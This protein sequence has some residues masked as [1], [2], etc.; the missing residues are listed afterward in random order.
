MNVEVVVGGAVPGQGSGSRGCPARPLGAGKEGHAGAGEV[1]LDG[2]GVLVIADRG[3]QRRG[4][5]EPAQ[6]V[7]HVCRRPA[8]V[9]NGAPRR[10]DDVHQGLAHNHYIGARVAVRLGLLGVI[11]SGP[12]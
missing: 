8:W 3:Q 5:A 2:R 1:L 11:H 12:P 7:G 10:D 9:L 6:S 4:Y